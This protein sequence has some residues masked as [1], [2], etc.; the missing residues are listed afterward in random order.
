MESDRD[1][2]Q[3]D[4][5]SR[6]RA[7]ALANAVSALEFLGEPRVLE[8]LK[9]V[10][11]IGNHQ[12]DRDLRHRMIFEI[13]FWPNHPVKVRHDRTIVATLVVT[14][15]DQTHQLKSEQSGVS[16]PWDGDH[17]ITVAF[18]QGEDTVREVVLDCQ[19]RDLGHTH[20][21]TVKDEEVREL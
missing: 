6:S 15:E 13:G 19:I 4:S 10:G 7:L 1:L 12:D 11:G 16:H 9:F 2:D 18:P 3:L 21:W 17:H 5:F 8:R 20:T 14:C